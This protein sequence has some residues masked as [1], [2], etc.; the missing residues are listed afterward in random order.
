MT[1]SR[2]R[3]RRLAVLAVAG[4]AILTLYFLFNPA[5]S[6]FA[7]KCI[8]HTLTGLDCPGCGS[9]RMVHALLHADF[10]SAWSANPFLLMSAPY[11]AFWIWV[12]TDPDANPRLHRAMNSPLAIVIILFFIIAWGIF[13]NL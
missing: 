9:Q 8:F 12:E 5:A 2:K 6:V 4:G 1:L 7:P 3:L 10:R 11:L 13:R